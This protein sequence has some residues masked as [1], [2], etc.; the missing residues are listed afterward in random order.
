MGPK[1]RLSVAER[2]QRPSAASTLAKKQ[3]HAVGGIASLSTAARRPGSKT[4]SSDRLS[5]STAG[6]AVSPSKKTGET[7]TSPAKKSAKTATRETPAGSPCK[8]KIEENKGTTRTSSRENAK[9]ASAEDQD[10]ENSKLAVKEDSNRKEAKEETGSSNSSNSSC[11]ANRVQDKKDGKNKAISKMLKNLDIKISGFDNLLPKEQS[12]QELGMKSSISENVKTKSR[13]AAVKV[14]AT[15]TTSKPI[16]R[17]KGNEED[18]RKVT[19]KSGNEK[20]KEN[21]KD[22]EGMKIRSSQDTNEEN[23]TKDSVTKDTKESEE[24]KTKEKCD[25]AEDLGNMQT[26]PDTLVKEEEKLSLIETKKKIA[27]KKARMESGQKQKKASANKGKSQEKSEEKDC[28][29]MQEDLKELPLNKDKE[30]EVV[31]EEDNKT[32][33]ERKAGSSFKVSP[34][35]AETSTRNELSPK[36]KNIL[37]EE[38]KQENKSNNNEEM[39][40]ERPKTPENRSLQH[41]PHSPKNSFTAKESTKDEQASET[42]CNKLDKEEGQLFEEKEEILKIIIDSNTEVVQMEI[43]EIARGKSETQPTQSPAND[44]TLYPKEPIDNVEQR[45][46]EV[47]KSL[48]PKHVPA[49][50]SKK[51]ATVKQRLQPKYKVN[52]I[53]P[54]I[55]KPSTKKGQYSSKAFVVANTKMETK[56]GDPN[57]IYDFKSGSEDEENIKMELPT[58]K[59][60]REFSEE[61]DKSI[62]KKTQTPKKEAAKYPSAKE[63]AKKEEILTTSSETSEEPR[64]KDVEKFAILMKTSSSTSKEKIQDLETAKKVVEAPLEVPGTANQKV[65]GEILDAEKNSSD[66]SSEESS[67]KKLPPNKN[68]SKPTKMMQKL[69]LTKKCITLKNL[70]TPKTLKPKIAKKLEKS[71]G[72]KAQKAAVKV[73][74]SGSSDSDDGKNLIIFSQKRHRMA[75]LNALAKVQ[76]LYE[77]ESRTA[78]ELGLSKATLLPPKIRTL[79]VSDEEKD[80][81]D[82]FKHKDKDNGKDKEKEKAKECPITSK[83]DEKPSKTK[84]DKKVEDPLRIEDLPAKDETEEERIEEPVCELKREQ[85]ND[86]GGRGFGKYWEFESDSELDE[87]EQMRIKKKK[88]QKKLQAKRERE[89][90]KEKQQQLK[91]KEKR[92]AE[93]KPKEDQPIKVKRKY[94]KIKKPLKKVVKLATGSTDDEAN[95][96]SSDKEDNEKEKTLKLKLNESKKPPK[97]RKRTLKEELIG[98]YKGILARKRMASLNASAIV[99]ATYEVER[100]LDRNLGHLS[101]YETYEDEQKTT[102]KKVKETKATAKEPKPAKSTAVATPLSTAVTATTTTLTITSSVS[103]ST[104]STT[105]IS[106]SPAAVT[107]NST[108]TETPCAPTSSTNACDVTSSS[109]SSSSATVTDSATTPK[110]SVAVEPKPHA[111]P[112]PTKAEKPSSICEES[113]DSKYSKDTKETNTDITTTT[114]SS[115]SGSS[116]TTSSTKEAKDSSR[117]TS[118]SV[119]IVQDT[120]VTITGVYVNSSAGAGQEAYCKMQYRVQSSVTEERLLRPGS[121]EPPPKSYTPLSAL[122][123]MLPP[124]ATAGGTEGTP[125]VSPP[126]TTTTSQTSASSLSDTLNAAAGLYNPADLGI[127]TEQGPMEHHG[128]PP[129]SY[130]AAAA[131]AAAA[132]HAHH[133]SPH[134]GSVHHQHQYAHVHAH[135]Q[136]QQAGAEHH[137]MPPPPHHYA[138]AS[139]PLPSSHYGPL[140]GH[141][142]A[143][144]PPPTYRANSGYPQ[145]VPGVSTAGGTP[146][147]TQPPLSAGLGGSAF[148]S[149][150]IHHQQQQQQAQ[151]SSQQQLGSQSGTNETS[152]KLVIYLTLNVVKSLKA[153]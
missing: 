143:G 82:E 131:A 75:S 91:N 15:L 68:P 61:E 148:C 97:K 79:D 38:E 115:S 106:T 4:T 41:A 71:K 135:H 26:K 73:R 103:S 42:K 6:S 24:G 81:K 149:T 107:T 137:G 49:K 31:E 27:A 80:R 147:S 78:Y 122:S 96:E 14:I 130:T 60:L 58:L 129:P 153:C 104:H 98:D 29:V 150:N 33:M 57:D 11:D 32:E 128:A 76:C 86:A 109:A 95:S 3:R 70:K 39:K 28:K 52:P 9:W 133:M 89:L 77:N 59:N 64:E 22:R 88:L 123:S 152:G 105:T 102:N 7:A 100:H 63:K 72:G 55:V 47:I 23:V 66:E 25:D 43:E 111:P 118:S 36:H 119:V 8:E 125:I 101:G 83:T 139:H 110:L 10:S 117:P 17:T 46:Q 50:E 16:K 54:K 1:R 146:I 142:E 62:V 85:R 74:S 99:A 84:K 138:G 56:P 30:Q 113:N 132:Y 48:S 51:V 151:Q 5:A 53:K 145:N 69:N 37:N 112:T 92:E 141:C 120:D 114:T 21:L 93:D 12:I 65:G 121:V 13:A 127:H 19:V 45:T 144:S 44:I 134:G 18:K 20:P 90:E 140:P 40:L 116:T 126:P 136:Y 124:G 35:E 108:E 87:I 2:Q 34:D 94:T 67:K